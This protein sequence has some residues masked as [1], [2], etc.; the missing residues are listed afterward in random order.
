MKKTAFFTLLA[1]IS[2]LTL[3]S[4]QKPAA[5]IS[6][7]TADPNGILK[8]NLGAEPTVLNPIL[9]T[10]AA[11]GG[12]VDLIFNGLFKVNNQLELIPDLATAYTLGDDGKTYTFFLKKNVLWQDGKPFTA[13]DVAFTMSKILDPATNT[14]RRPQYIIN[15]KPVRFKVLDP[16]TIQ[17]IL[18]EPFSPFLVSMA[19]G[20]LP[21]HLLDG[22]NINTASFNRQPVGTGP[23]KFKKWVSGQYVELERNSLY[24]GSKPKLKGIL[25][26]II[27]DANTALVALEKGETD[28]DQVPAKEFDRITQKGQLQ[29]YRYYGLYYTF[30]GFNLKHPLLSDHKIREAIAY[31]INRDALTKSVLKGFGKPA[32]IPESPVSWAYPKN[33]KTIPTYSY[34]PAKST[35][36]LTQLGYKKNA[37]TGFFEK[38]GKPIEFTVITNKGNK[39]REKSATIIQRYLQNAGI[40]LNIQ[41]MEWSAFVK[42]LN[43]PQDPKPFDAVLL[44]WSTGIDPDGYSIWHSSEYPSGFNLIGYANLKAD[45][46]L[47]QGR[48]QTQKE[49]R[50]KTYAQLYSVIS[51]DIPY[52]FMFYPESTVGA[53]LKLRGLSKPGPAGLLNKIEDV[54]LVK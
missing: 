40:K 11:S 12:V 30:L 8:L 7:G 48:R 39:D 25:Q 51:G 43:S 19:I 53:S 45:Q 20:M 42:L 24:F 36:I 16:Y 54:Y 29:T 34:N 28:I 46:L 41:I 17:A 1:I 38:N 32:T 37:S 4:C 10:D 18:P 44:G 13:E 14:V 15:G 33:D 2:I 21:K 52:Y 35:E 22:Q 50:Q 27:P 26:K 47:V 3:T 9:Y 31:A 5:I 49:D 23:F 6:E